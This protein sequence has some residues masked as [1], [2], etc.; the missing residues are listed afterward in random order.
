[1]AGLAAAVLVRRVVVT[2]AAVGAIIASVLAP[3]AVAQLSSTYY[4]GSC[5]SLQTIVRST[6]TAAVQLE[7]RMGASI[8]RL[9]FHDCFVNGCDASVLLDDSSTLTGEKNAAPNANSLRGFEVIDSIKTQLEVACPGT[10]SCADILAVAARDGV[11]LLGGPTWAVPLGRRDARTASQAAANSN[12]PSPS[13]SASALVSAFASLGLDSRDMV[14]LS[15]AHTIGSARCAIFRSRV[16]N[17]SNINPGFA[18]RRRQVCPVQGGDANLAPLDALSSVRFDNGYF[19]NLMGRFGLLHSDQELFSGGPV[20]SIAQQYAANGAAFSRDFVTAVVKMGN[21]SPLTGSNGE[22][23]S[24]C[25]KP[26]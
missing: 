14:A 23:R 10:V 8:L 19:R 4:D 3:G 2:V 13:S 15:G 22:I 1:M 11:N 12:L 24:N 21:I 7:P 25:R 5:P 9:F 17:E 26:N 18:T 20:D 16:Y 6:M